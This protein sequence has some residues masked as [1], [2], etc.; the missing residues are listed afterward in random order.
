[1]REPPREPP[2]DWQLSEAKNRFSEVV[3]RALSEGPQRVRRRQDSVV[4]MSEREFLKLSGEKLSFSA[5]LRQG[6]DL[7]DLDLARDPSPMRESKI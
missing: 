6:P 4:V 7:S 3:R 2:V 5:F 1:M